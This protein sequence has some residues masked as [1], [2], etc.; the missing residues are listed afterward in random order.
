M[1]GDLRVGSVV[2]DCNDFPTMSHFWQE[3]LRYVPREEPE[4]DWVVLKDPE[5]RSVQVQRILQDHLRLANRNGLFTDTT[6]V[7]PVLVSG[8]Q[9][10]WPVS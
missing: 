3:A 9:P 1:K 5:G 10:D 6:H 4:D 7:S 2:I 8:S